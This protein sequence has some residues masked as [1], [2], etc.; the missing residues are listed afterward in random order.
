[1]EK[2]EKKDKIVISNGDKLRRWIGTLWPI[3]VLI[4]VGVYALTQLPGGIEKVEASLVQHE[5]ANCE[6]HKATNK[7][8]E[9]LRIEG[10]LFSH[11]NERRIIGMERDISYTKEATIRI[12]M[13]LKELREVLAKINRKYE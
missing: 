1:M 5:K 3:V 4:V 12:E 11:A 13:G 6:K 9:I 7:K 10:T 8:I 2:P